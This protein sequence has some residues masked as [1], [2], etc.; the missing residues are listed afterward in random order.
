MKT[1][2]LLAGMLP[3]AMVQAQPEPTK[4]EMAFEH[5]I[6]LYADDRQ[7]EA[8]LAFYEFM[9]VYPDSPLRPSAH[10]NIGVLQF[11]RQ[12]YEVAAGV[13]KQILNEEYNEF[14]SNS[15]MEPYKLYK[16]QSCRF[17]A[18]I[19]FEQKDFKAAEEYIHLFENVYPYQHFCGNELTAYAIYTATMKA[20]LYEGQQ[21]VEKA[22]QT[23][24]PFT[25]QNSLA[26]NEELLDLL[27]NILY[28]H[29][30][31][32]QVQQELTNAIASIQIKSKKRDTDVTMTLFGERIRFDDFMF[33]FEGDEKHDVT[34]YQKIAKENILFTRFL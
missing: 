7:D 32:E 17:L 25:F 4:D 5:A 10:F 20:R 30:T 11:N 28:R 29:Y 26:S 13:F 18:E 33:D 15:L 2:L 16:H 12:H 24:I 34:Y 31:K 22:I 3:C 6:S 9:T 1:L 19:S 8:L 14:D 23:L 27:I 21:K